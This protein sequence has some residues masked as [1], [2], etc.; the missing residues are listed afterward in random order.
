[1]HLTTSISIEFKLSHF[2]CF[3]TTLNKGILMHFIK[4]VLKKFLID[5]RH[6]FVTVNK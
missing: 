4:D 6:N 5:I 2:N 1:M 3:K